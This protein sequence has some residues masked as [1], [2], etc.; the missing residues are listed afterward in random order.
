MVHYRRYFK[1]NSIF[2]Y[3]IDKNGEIINKDA[4]I[5]SKSEIEK[6]LAETDI[7][8]PE[9]RNYYIETIYSHYG[10][11]LNAGDLD[12]TRQIILEKYPL[13]VLDYDNVI[14]SKKAFMFNMFI[15]KK[16]MFNQYCE[17][18]FDI[19]AELEKRIDTDG[20]TDFQKRLYGRV[21]E[22]LLNVWVEKHNYKYKEV[23]VVNL[24]GENWIKKGTAFLCAKI[25]KKKYEKSF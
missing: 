9:K 18:L 12:M 11:T 6:M 1:G 10:N 17:W 16:E 15:M 20:Y 23:P 19:L 25:F 2:K 5:L 24:E 8:V 7:I 4:G 3:H 13:Y 21:S 22:I 14:N